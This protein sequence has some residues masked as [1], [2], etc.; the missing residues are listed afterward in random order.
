MSLARPSTENSNVRSPTINKVMVP[1]QCHRAATSRDG[2][3]PKRP[4]R[5]VAEIA[6][7]RYPVP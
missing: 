2:P 5:S 1:D 7:L 3:H 4:F 6:V